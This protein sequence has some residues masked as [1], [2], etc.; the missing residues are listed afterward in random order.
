MPIVADGINPAPPPTEMSNLFQRL[1]SFLIAVE[2]RTFSRL[3]GSIH[4]LTGG[5]VPRPQQGKGEPCCFV[6]RHSD[7][8]GAPVRSGSSASSAAP[9]APKWAMGDR[10][11]QQPRRSTLCPFLKKRNFDPH[12]DEYLKALCDLWVKEIHGKPTTSH[13]KGAAEASG[14][15]KIAHCGRAGAVTCRSSCRPNSSWSS[16]SGPQR[17]SG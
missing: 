7:R 11:A 15:Y 1:S 2:Y 6:L 5:R 10:V 16:T 17:R 3:G 12:R 8:P 13:R 9:I 14:P 4:I